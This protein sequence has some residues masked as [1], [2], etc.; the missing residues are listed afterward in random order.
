MDVANSYDEAAGLYNAR[1]FSEAS[2]LFSKLVRHDP[3][4]PVFAYAMI[5]SLSEL[6]V[7]NVAER[8]PPE[9]EE[10]REQLGV[11]FRQENLANALRARGFIVQVETENH[12]AEVLAEKHGERFLVRFSDIF[13]GISCD[14]FRAT[15]GEDQLEHIEPSTLRT[16][17][18]REI[19]PL[20]LRSHLEIYKL[21]H[22]Y[23]GKKETPDHQ[24]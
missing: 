23:D 1:R 15:R 5:M 20:V 21:S 10:K 7:R 17:V 8:L 13:L 4:N 2:D 6:G 22:A 3:T 12:T 18:E 11:I 9:L 24:E 16:A 19:Y 14:T